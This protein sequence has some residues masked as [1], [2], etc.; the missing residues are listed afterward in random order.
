MLLYDYVAFHKFKVASSVLDKQQLTLSLFCKKIN[1]INKIKVFD[2]TILHLFK[3]RNCKHL[4]KQEKIKE[5]T[6][7][8]YIDE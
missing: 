5:T 1:L 4:T 3:K 2:I 6:C 7:N 8:K